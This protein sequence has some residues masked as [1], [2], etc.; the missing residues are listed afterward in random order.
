MLDIDSDYMCMSILCVYI[1]VLAHPLPDPECSLLY[2]H[3]VNM[4]FF[5]KFLK[6]ISTILLVLMALQFFDNV[7]ESLV[8]NIS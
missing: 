6:Y 7:I 8:L 3:M 1:Y 5:V 2:I 4:Y